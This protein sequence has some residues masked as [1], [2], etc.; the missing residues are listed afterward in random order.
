MPVSDIHI[1]DNRHKYRHRKTDSVERMRVKKKIGKTNQ[2]SSERICMNQ[3]SVSV[4]IRLL[5]CIRP[6]SPKESNGNC[7]DIN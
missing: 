7:G 6:L 3:Q 1:S 4:N 5:S 2:Q